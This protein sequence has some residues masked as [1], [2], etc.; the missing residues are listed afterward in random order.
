MGLFEQRK[1]IFNKFRKMTHLTD[2]IVNF[3]LAHMTIV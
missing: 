1:I 2:E 3:G